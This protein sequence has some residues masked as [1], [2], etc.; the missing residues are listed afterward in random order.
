MINCP[1]TFRPF[2]PLPESLTR[3]NARA[4]SQRPAAAAEQTG[5]TKGLPHHP[6]G[7]LKKR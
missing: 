5:R 7:L 6:R 3:A 1:R 4:V 2:S